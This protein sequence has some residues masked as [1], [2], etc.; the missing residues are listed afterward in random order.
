M[1]LL[2]IG[3]HTFDLLFFVVRV[4]IRSI[5]NW[6]LSR[7]MDRHFRHVRFPHLIDIL[8]DKFD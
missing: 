2:Q 1:C 5:A 3:D 8:F 6:F 4:T 7:Q